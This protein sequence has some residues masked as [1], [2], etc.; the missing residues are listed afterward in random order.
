MSVRQKNSNEEGKSS[1]L[2]SMSTNSFEKIELHMKL[3][4]SIF[5]YFLSTWVVQRV[6]DFLKNRPNQILH[7][8]FFSKMVPYL[9]FIKVYLFKELQ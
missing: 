1:L 3:V 8:D 9:R 2:D 6:K 5:E 7:E 4:L